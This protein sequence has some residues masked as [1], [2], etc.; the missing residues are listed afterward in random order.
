MANIM[1]EQSHELTHE[2]AHDRLKRL[3]DFLA[4]KHGLH[5]VWNN[6]EHVH[7]TGKVMLVNVDAT[8]SLTPGRV[9]LFGKDPGAL[10]RKTVEDFLLLSIKKYLDPKINA[11][12]LPS[13]G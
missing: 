13:A 8:V 5:V 11:A 4:R 9:K 3:G 2:D 10:F 12:Q 1:I 7:V 6:D